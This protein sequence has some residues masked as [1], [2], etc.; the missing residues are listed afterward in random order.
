M[1]EGGGELAAAALSAGV[2]NKVAFFLAPKI[3]LGRDSIPVV[4]GNS[5]VELSQAIGIDSLQVEQV[6]QDWLLT[7]ECKNVYRDS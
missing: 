2:V 3:L 7:G 4:G 6:G 5:V 1:L